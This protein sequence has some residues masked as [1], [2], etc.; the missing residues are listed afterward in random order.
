MLTVSTMR[1]TARAR[2]SRS[3]TARAAGSAYGASHAAERDG[4]QDAFFC[5]ASASPGTISPAGWPSFSARLASSRALAA[6]LL[7]L[8]GVEVD[9]LLAGEPHD[10]VH[11]LVGDRAQDVAVV[12]HALVAG[13]VQ[14]R[15]EA[16]DRTG[17]GAELLAGRGDDVGADDG[18]RDHGHLGLQRQPGDPGLAA[19]EPTVVRA[20]AFG[21][22]AEQV[23][24]LEDL[25]RRRQGALRGR[26]PRCGRSGPARRRRRTSSGTSP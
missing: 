10:L 21:I 26:R 6:S 4:A 17:E 20:G 3:S 25:S 23:A 7:G 11:D 19:V 18:H 9:V 12:L 8:A 16:H 5:S 1:S 15:A 2:K 24:L 22:D 13:E 14:R